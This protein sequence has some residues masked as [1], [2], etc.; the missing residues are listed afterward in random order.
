MVGEDKRIFHSHKCILAARSPVFEKMFFGSLPESS[1]KS[2]SLPDVDSDAF[3]AFL[4]FMY[5]E[6]TFEDMA[7]YAVEHFSELNYI[8]EKYM[9]PEFQKL[10]VDYLMSTEDPFELRC[11]FSCFQIAD[12]I[13]SVNLLKKYCQV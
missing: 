4:N 12:S 10:Y 8:A 9:V 6:D 11:L 3:E 5:N 1:S 2:I 7:L 13:D